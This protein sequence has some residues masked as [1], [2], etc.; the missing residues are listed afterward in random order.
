MLV[1]VT[2]VESFDFMRIHP[3][4]F[5][6]LGLCIVPDEFLHVREATTDA[7]HQFIVHNFCVD[8]L[9]AEHVPAV[10]DTGDWDLTILDIEDACEHLI[11]AVA[12]HRAI[13]ARSDGRHFESLLNLRSNELKLVFKLLSLTLKFAKLDLTCFYRFFHLSH[14]AIIRV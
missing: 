5:Q 3:L 2:R 13:L 11:D 4:K 9:R 7:T 6:S 1:H 12:L 14:A 8:F 10:T